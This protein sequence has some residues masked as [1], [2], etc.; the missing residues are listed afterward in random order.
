MGYK[1]QSKK[2]SVFLV[3]NSF[4]NYSITITAIYYNNP[5]KRINSYVTMILN[6]MKVN[7]HIL[8]HPDP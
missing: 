4:L 7:T 1:C 6:N 8:C 3:Y 5:H 2:W